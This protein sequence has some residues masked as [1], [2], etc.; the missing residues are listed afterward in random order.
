MS[1]QLETSNDLVIPHA[2]HLSAKFLNVV[3]QRCAAENFG[4]TL[5]PRQQKQRVFLTGKIR[6]GNIWMRSKERQLVVFA[7]PAG[8]SLHV[9]WQLTSDDQ[10]LSHVLSQSLSTMAHMNDV[11]DARPE[12]QRQLMT[13]LHS[14]N[15]LVFEPVVDLLVEAV[16]HH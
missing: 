11:I 6:F 8:R 7:D 4:L 9:G 14:F 10:M 13:I 16:E 3:Q 12:F 5:S 1:Q 15:D 2:A